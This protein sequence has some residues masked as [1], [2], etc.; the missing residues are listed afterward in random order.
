MY[1]VVGYEEDSG[2]LHVRAVRCSLSIGN[3]HGISLLWPYTARNLNSIA[4][5][6]G[7]YRET[8]IAFFLALSCIYEVLEDVCFLNT[9]FVELF[10]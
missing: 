8:Q 4:N 5:G 10:D 3:C 6:D 9:D 7:V 2:V 1:S